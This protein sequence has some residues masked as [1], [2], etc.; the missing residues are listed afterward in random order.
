MA[1]EIC[2]PYL[3]KNRPLFST[4]LLSKNK[5]GVKEERELIFEGGVFSGGYGIITLSNTFDTLFI[6]L[7]AAMMKAQCEADMLN[8]SRDLEKLKREKVMWE[9]AQK[10]GDQRGPATTC[11]EQV[12]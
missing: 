10:A 4:L 3:P 2:V 8:M 12:G 11:D 7:K 1:S 6:L 5:E 9:M